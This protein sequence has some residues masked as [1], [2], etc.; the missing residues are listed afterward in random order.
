MVEFDAIN[1]LIVRLSNDPFNPELN[2]AIAIEYNKIG[3]TASAVSFYLRTAEYGYDTHPLHVYASL[4]KCAECFEIQQGREN[5]VRN[6]FE[7]AIAY[8]PDRPEAWLLY[9][10]HYEVRQKYQESYTAAEI[11][12]SKSDKQPPLPL[13]VGYTGDYELLFE[14]AVSGWWVGRKDEAIEIFKQLLDRKDTTYQYRLGAKRNL[15]QILGYIDSIDPLESVV[16][17]YRKHFGAEANVIVDIGT[18]DGDDA[19]YLFRKLYA[20]T[21]IAIDANPDAVSLTK[22]KYPWMTVIYSAVTEKEGP[23]EFNK[24]IGNEIEFTGTSSIFNKDKSIDPPADFYKGKVQTITVPANRM[25][26]ILASEN[27]TGPI[28]VVKIDTEGYS[29][30][31]LQGF[32][33]RLKDVKLFH[34]E[35]EKVQVHDDHVLSDQIVEFMRSNGFVL[36]DTSYE[37]GWS[38]EDQIWVNPALA[39]RN[40]ECF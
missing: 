16:T 4:L 12:L 21:A 1:N 20:T 26:T 22:N 39:T 14:K 24:V 23:V 37:W 15:I 30:Q 29:W 2:F 31:V 5:T 7:K 18:T 25:D 34:I 35:T 27:I 10:R 9:S 3:Q 40:T 36:V 11:G 32:G 28:D 6:L 17:M 38:I 13:L 8:L 33:E 19:E